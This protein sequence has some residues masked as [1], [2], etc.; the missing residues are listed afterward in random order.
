MLKELAA[1]ATTVTPPVQ[2]CKTQQCIS[3]V[4][5]TK[6]GFGPR[7]NIMKNYG[8]TYTIEND[9][10]VITNVFPVSEDWDG[11]RFHGYCR[12]TVDEIR[13]AGF[14]VAA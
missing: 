8:A 7:K 2:Q 9:V 5:L 6:R 1:T 4:N 11:Y 3:T 14:E 12:P 10:L 13:A